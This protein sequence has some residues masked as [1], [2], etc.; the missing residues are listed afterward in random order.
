[1]AV[2]VGVRVLCWRFGSKGMFP[3]C[4]GG[5]KSAF[6]RLV[7]R[8]DAG[9]CSDGAGRLVAVWCGLAFLDGEGMKK[10]RGKG[11]AG[12]GCVSSVLLRSLV[13]GYAPS[14]SPGLFFFLP[15]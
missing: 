5:E 15:E 3:L 6:K 13:V 4:S 12:G 2:V 10:S 11:G 14:S 9:A 7:L 8:C 1:M